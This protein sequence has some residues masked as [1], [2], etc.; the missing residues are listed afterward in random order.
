MLKNTCKHMIGPHIAPAALFRPT[1]ADFKPPKL[2]DILIYVCACFKEQL[3]TETH[4]IQGFFLGNM[5]EAGV[6]WPFSELY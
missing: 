6:K 2:D 5:K 3:S 1:E 4:H